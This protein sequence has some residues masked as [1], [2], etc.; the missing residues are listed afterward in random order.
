[1][2]RLLKSAAAMSCVLLFA[3]S[4]GG[5]LLGDLRAHAMAALPDYWPTDGWRTSPPELQGVS[6]ARLRD[7]HDYIRA[8]DLPLD[9]MV[10]VRNGYIVYEDYPN[11]LMYDEDSL[12]VLHSVTKSFT[13]ALIGI[14]I[15]QGY[16]GSVHDSAISYFPHRTIANLDARKQAMTI[17]DLLNMVAGMQWDEWSYPY[18]DS[19]NTYRQMVN[20]RDWVQFILDRP[21]AVEP[22]TEFVYCGGASHLLGAIVRETT[23]LTPLQY[24]CQ[25]LFE[26]L[27]ITNVY[28][29]TDPSGL[30]IGGAA[31]YLETRDMAKFGFLYLN[32]GTWAGQQVVPGAWV[33]Q[34]RRSA[35]YPWTGAGYGY[36]WWKALTLGSFEARGLY[37]QWIVVQPA[38]QL[39]VALTASDTEGRIWLEELFSYI[40]GAIEDFVPFNPGTLLVLATAVLA[41]GGA[42]GAAGVYFIRKRRRS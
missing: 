35:V 30:N 4:L 17:E 1:M 39:V 25:F 10:V 31:L 18:T 37:N 34:S 26:P 32:N 38:N 20:T 9:S 19:R 16:I 2:R 7:L 29:Q 23:G 22:G 28:W 5:G 36:Q 24:A 21:M 11:P 41:L 13:S 3:I 8:E 42:F 27:G 33:A 12:H 14:A 6:S 40:T 15:Q